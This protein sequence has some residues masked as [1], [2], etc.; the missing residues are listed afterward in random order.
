VTGSFVAKDNRR[1]RL[2]VAEA[3]EAPV[4]DTSRIVL[5]PANFLH[6][7][8][9]IEQRWP[10]AIRFVQERGLNEHFGTAADEIG[11]IV[12]GGLF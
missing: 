6:E 3:A 7:V 2:T 10:A 1:P 12:Q 9:K 4:R 11:I 8:E 5:P